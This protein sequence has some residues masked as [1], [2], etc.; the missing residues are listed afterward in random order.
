MWFMALLFAA[1]AAGCGGG[2]GGSPILGSG[3]TPPPLTA[4]TLVDVIKPRVALT[5]PANGEVVNAPFNAAITATLN[6][7][8]LATTIN[9]PAVSFTVL[10][11]TTGIPVAATGVTYDAASKTAT[12]THAGLTP[13]NNYSATIHGVGVS[14]ATD[15]AGN[16]LAGGLVGAA[17]PAVAADYTWTFTA[18]AVDVT[19]PTITLE[20]PVDLATNV[21]LNSAVNATFSEAMDPASITFAVQTFGPPLGAALTGVVSYD[22]LT[23]IATFTPAANLVANTK[24]QATVTAAKDLAGN[25]LVVPAV[26]V[27][28]NAWT[29][30]TGTGLAPGAIN[31]GTAN[32]FGIMATSAITSTGASLINGDVS[33][34]P[35]TSMGIPPTQV[36]GSIHVNDTVSHQAR[37]DL[38]AAYNTAKALAP[39]VGPNALGAGADLGALFPA[40]VPPGTYTS[41]STI[42]LNTPVTL[43]AKGDANAV[44]VFQIGS[45]LTTGTN[46]TLANGAQSKNVFWVP[47]SDATIGVGTIFYG[48]LVTGRDATAVTGSTINGRILAGAITAGTVALQAATVNVP[49]P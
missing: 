43:D 37:A 21:A 48:T 47:T 9:S 40:G 1:L 4:A 26:G 15:V 23:K 27:P 2:G 10:N 28:A 32:S 19:P 20:S 46:V 3:A 11:T 24:Y 17:N 12:F 6:E 25:L 39:G 34:E 49:A 41:G 35:G 8:M 14:V 31:L 22:P 18:T 44:W 16:P 29:F 7:A 36:N 30:T 45:S 33:L 38:L 42:I 5:F 13:G